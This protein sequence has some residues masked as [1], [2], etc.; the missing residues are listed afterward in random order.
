VRRLVARAEIEA[1]RGPAGTLK[2]SEREELVELRRE[3]RRLWMEREILKRADAA[4]CRRRRDSPPRRE[5][6]ST[7]TARYNQPS[8]V[9]HTRCHIE[10]A[11]RCGTR[12]LSRA[13][14]FPTGYEDRLSKYGLG[15]QRSEWSNAC[16]WNATTSNDSE[17]GVG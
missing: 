17:S 12:Y 1:G 11:I 14:S 16:A 8:R 2:R 9:L 13:A 15:V 3:N 7:I 5:N 4:G 10:Q 6:R